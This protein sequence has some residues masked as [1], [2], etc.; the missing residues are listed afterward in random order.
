M[1][2]DHESQRCL[3]LRL[4]LTSAAIAVLVTL[5]HHFGYSSGVESRWIDAMGLI[6]RPAP[7]N[8]VVVVTVTDAD[9]AREDLF[10]SV[11]PMDPKTLQRTFERIADH[12]PAVVAIDI[13]LQ[14][15]PHESGERLDRRRQLYRSLANLVTTRSIRWILVRPDRVDAGAGGIDPD[16]QSN[17]NA[18][19]QLADAS[20]KH[21]W[22]ASPVMQDEEGLIR[23]M[24]F[25]EPASD[26]QS[27]ALTIFGATV[28]TEARHEETLSINHHPLLIRYTGAFGLGTGLT[29]NALGVG[30]LLAPEVAPK[31][32]TILTGKTVIVGGSHHAGRD[33][34]WTPIGYLPAV[35]IW[36]EAVDTFNRK[37]APREPHWLV[38]LLLETGVGIMGGWLMLRFNPMIGYALTLLILAPL[39]IGLASLAF[40]TGLLFVNFLPSFLGV[41]LHERIESWYEMR[42][43]RNQVRTLRHQVTDLED[44]LRILRPTKNGESTVT[45]TASDEQQPQ[46]TTAPPKASA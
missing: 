30:D 9:F 20:P 7:T 25:N 36:A 1:S 4:S 34:H 43:L 23:H 42:K 33:Y 40:G 16:V 28:E 5:L 27:S 18:L 46:R 29:P 6:H 12:R 31:G 11:S 10:A 35:Q 44:Q 17:W 8:Q 21:L 19:Q 41:R 13:Q 14:P 24:S 32:D 45:D 38:A 22:W 39:T 15:V 3:I 2:H 37:D 26:E